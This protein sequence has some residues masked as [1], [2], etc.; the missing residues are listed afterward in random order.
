MKIKVFIVDFEISPRVKRWALRIGIPAVVLGGAAVALASPPHVCATGDPLQAVDLNSLQA[1]ITA[2]QSFQAQATADGGYAL[3]AKYCGQT[4]AVSG[5]AFGGHAGAK[6][7]CQAVSTC[8]ASA[9]LC[10][11][12]ELTR[13]A[14]LGVLPPV[15]S[16][17]GRRGSTIRATTR[18]VRASTRAIRPPSP[19]TVA[20]DPWP[21]G[22][23]TARASMYSCCRRTRLRTR[24]ATPLDP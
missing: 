21:T 14:S 10:T 8:G 19:S 3:G 13:S 22:A 5:T 23:T 7:L 9:H 17:G 15:N 16:A 2:L 20:I 4:S 1:Q 6:A 12:E 11:G 24:P 18:M